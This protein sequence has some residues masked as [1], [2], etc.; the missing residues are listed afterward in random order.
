MEPHPS[1]LSH[2]LH[3][4]LAA[5]PLFSTTPKASGDLGP[6]DSDSWWLM[7]LADHHG[8]FPRPPSQVPTALRA[9][10]TALGSTRWIAI[11]Q[12]NSAAAI[13]GHHWRGSCGPRRWPWGN[14]GRDH[15][16]SATPRIFKLVIV[17]TG[18]HR[19]Q[20]CCANHC[21]SSGIQVSA[22]LYAAL[23]RC[24]LTFT[25]EYLA[26]WIVKKLSLRY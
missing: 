7:I 26:Q 2:F 24:C 18:Q 5:F 12:C 13:S 10:A 4:S 6:S 19:S 15:D 1:A 16:S 25:V 22:L 9:R 17:C 8:H 23:I 14:H 11:F 20:P 3:A 21:E